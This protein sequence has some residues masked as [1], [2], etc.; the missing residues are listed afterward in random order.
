MIMLLTT[1]GRI[2]TPVVSTSRKRPVRTSL[3]N[4]MFIGKFLIYTT[5]RPSLF[6]PTLVKF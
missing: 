5:F 1:N 3:Y 4:I 2:N 6:F